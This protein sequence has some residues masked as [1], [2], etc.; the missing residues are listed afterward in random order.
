MK[1]LIKYEFTK[2]LRR[3]LTMVA[4]LVSLAVTALLFGLPCLQFQ[5]VKQEDSIKGIEGIEAMKED[6]ADQNVFIT[7]TLVEESIEEVTELF[8]DKDNVGYDGT[9]EFL[10]GDAYW[11][12]VAPKETLLRLIASNY[13]PEGE[14]ASY[15]SL[16]T[17]SKENAE[18][19]YTIRED[20][21]NEI[22][23]DSTYEMSAAQKAFW[24]EK[25]DSVKTP[26]EYGY[27]ESWKIL[28]TCF[29]LFIVAMLSISICVAPVFCGEY[30][31]GT[32]AVI[33][34]GKYGKTK[35]STAKIIASMIFATLAYLVHVAVALGV[36]FIS[37]GVSGGNLPIQA[38]GLTIPYALTYSQ[39]MVKNLV[40]I[41]VVLM[42]IVALTLLLS[43]KSKNA[44][45]VVAVL[46]PIFFIPVFMSPNGVKG[47]FNFILL[48]MPYRATM[49]EIGKY[50]SFDIFGMT[51]DLWTVRLILYALLLTV[52]IPLAK[53]GFRKHQVA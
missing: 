18:N 27:H 44:L 8:A 41:Y 11:N 14:Y 2:Y 34:S 46:I 28:Y 4:M 48:M 49:P 38:D 30:Q 31:S 19:F 52:S 40:I 21:I 25:V 36:I 43:A 51:L 13:V 33:L 35:L 22:L 12:N 6:Y 9:E 3:K 24:R 7:E 39:V 17:L 37:F 16:R 47:V 1:T 15:E 42:A 23:N 50:I 32:D 53:N 10:I 26:I 29:E 45:S 5:Y 20:K